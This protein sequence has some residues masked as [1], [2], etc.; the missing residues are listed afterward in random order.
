MVHSER[1]HFP[2]AMLIE[3]KIH[4]INILY[5]KEHTRFNNNIFYWSIRRSSLQMNTPMPC[6]IFHLLQWF[7]RRDV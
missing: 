4:N 2:F 7:I 5:V 1:W 6:I 3:I